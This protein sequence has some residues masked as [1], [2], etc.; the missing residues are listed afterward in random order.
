MNSGTE[1]YDPFIRG[2]L[3]VGVRTIE[4]FDAVRDRQFPCEIWYPAGFVRGLTLCHLDAFLRGNEAARR[5]WAGDIEAKLEQR[6][7]DAIIHKS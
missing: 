7:I 6:G 1:D 5:F 3:P 4:V 2:G